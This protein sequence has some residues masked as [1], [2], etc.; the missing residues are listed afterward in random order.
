MTRNALSV[1]FLKNFFYSEEPFTVVGGRL[2]VISR[3]KNNNGREKLHLLGKSYSLEESE[4]IAQL[5]KELFLANRTNIE[6][7]IS[8]YIQKNFIN[9]IESTK[10]DILKKQNYYESIQDST[11]ERFIMVDVFNAYNHENRAVVDKIQTSKW[12][13]A[14]K[15]KDLPSVNDLISRDNSLD[16]LCSPYGFIVLGNR[17][18]SLY[19]NGSKKDEREGY[20]IFRDKVL[21]LKPWLGLDELCKQYTD[22]LMQRI[23]LK[24]EEHGKEFARILEQ[25]KT[26]KVRLEQGIKENKAIKNKEEDNRG[27][28][29]FKKLKENQYEISAIIP[30]Y[31]IGKNGSYHIFDSVVLGMVVKARNN[32]IMLDHAPKVL[33]TPYKHPFVYGN[34]SICYGK[35]NWQN[36]RGVR[37]NHWYSLNNK[38]MVAKRIAEAL[39]EGKKKME[40]GYVGEEVIGG[41]PIADYK[42]ADNLNDAKKY[43]QNNNVL[44]ERIIKND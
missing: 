33:N 26:D 22:N 7:M 25:M 10:R 6:S 34:G 14:P 36:K 20:V 1:H 42:I 8:G 11:I 5:E 39:R 41:H 31:I 24:A 9:K 38:N 29:G 30:P 35:L 32:Q 40:H 23:N 27:K 28:I 12:E 17:C 37:F 44:I 15:L 4:E 21:N 2:Y 18:Y 16:R 43:A 19:E 13:N 3:D